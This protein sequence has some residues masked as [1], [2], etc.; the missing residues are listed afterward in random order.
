VTFFPEFIHALLDRSSQEA[1]AMLHMYLP[2]LLSNDF[3]TKKCYIDV[4]AL[5]VRDVLV[6]NPQWNMI[7]QLVLR[8]FIASPAFENGLKRLVIHFVFNLAN[9]KHLNF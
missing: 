6:R 5:A 3:E 2:Y 9:I 7:A 1:L 4:L 8:R